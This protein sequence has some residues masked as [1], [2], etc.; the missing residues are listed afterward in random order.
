MGANLHPQPLVM[1]VDSCHPGVKYI[2]VLLR[3][4][5]AWRFHGNLWHKLAMNKNQ[6]KLPSQIRMPWKSRPYIPYIPVWFHPGWIA[7]K[8][9][10]FGCSRVATS[11]DSQLV[12][13]GDGVR[14]GMTYLWLWSMVLV[15]CFDKKVTTEL[16]S[17]RN[18]RI[19]MII[20]FIY[21]LYILG[22]SQPH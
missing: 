12:G 15:W 14:D 9:S 16:Y 3:A 18:S 11:F 4:A 2:Q 17:R 19:F 20:Y 10:R 21:L 6:P 8:M 22:I 7:S 13:T 1:Q 5:R